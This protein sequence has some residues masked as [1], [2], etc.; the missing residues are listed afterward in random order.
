ME[1]SAFL[2][3]IRAKILIILAGIPWRR[4]SKTMIPLS[5]SRSEISSSD[6]QNLES[7]LRL[8]HNNLKKNLSI[9]AQKT[10]PKAQMKIWNGYWFSV[11]LRRRERKFHVGF[12]WQDIISFRMSNHSYYCSKMRCTGKMAPP[13]ESLVNAHSQHRQNFSSGPSTS[14][15]WTVVGNIH[16]FYPPFDR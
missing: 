7:S 15:F 9:Q 4:V 8:C 1:N 13:D 14:N 3:S 2:Y 16:N 12:C 6:C 10:L 11:V 5:L